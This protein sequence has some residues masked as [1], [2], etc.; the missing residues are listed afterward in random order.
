MNALMNA[1]V[2]LQELDCSCAYA[3]SPPVE[4]VQMIQWVGAM[5]VKW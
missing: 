2:Q 3:L 5:A 1:N 4:V